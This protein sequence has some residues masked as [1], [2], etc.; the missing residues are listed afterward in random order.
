[1][2]EPALAWRGSWGEIAGIAGD[3]PWGLTL[4]SVQGCLWA[5]REKREIPFLPLGVYSGLLWLSV[6]QSLALRVN[7]A[8]LF[9]PGSLFAKVMARENFQVA[10]KDVTRELQSLV[11]RVA[12]K[13][14]HR[15]PPS[16]AAARPRPGSQSSRWLHHHEQGGTRRAGRAASHAPPREFPPVSGVREPVRV[17]SRRGV[18]KY[19]GEK[20]YPHPRLKVPRLEAEGRFLW[21]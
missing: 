8:R 1:M 7:A 2:Q 15:P 9:F 11:R 19:R 17:L 13:D 4:H 14:G 12:L 21:R 20:N 6:L 5:C 16:W 10:S 18:C 3:F